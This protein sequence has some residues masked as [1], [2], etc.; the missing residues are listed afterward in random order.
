[1]LGGVDMT[2][3]PRKATSLL[4]TVNVGCSRTQNRLSCVLSVKPSLTFSSPAGNSS[5]KRIR[6]SCGGFCWDVSA[7]MD[8][9]GTP[10]MLG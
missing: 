1:M 9:R 6:G 5:N 7:A 2:Q 10:D 3:N 8:K 4:K